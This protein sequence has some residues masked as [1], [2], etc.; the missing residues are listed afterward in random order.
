M[1]FKFYLSEFH[2]WVA[3]VLINVASYFKFYN[4]PKTSKGIEK[5]ADYFYEKSLSYYDLT[6]SDI[7]DMMENED[8]ID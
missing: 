8:M 3:L 7:K 4:F 1:D 5:I 6:P 2:V